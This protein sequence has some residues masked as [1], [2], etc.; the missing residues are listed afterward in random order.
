LEE[1]HVN[2]HVFVTTDNE[3]IRILYEDFDV[4]LYA[5][6]AQISPYR[7]YDHEHMLSALQRSSN[8]VQLL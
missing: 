6:K 7:N 5:G 1:D 3:E 2:V 8:W 4:T